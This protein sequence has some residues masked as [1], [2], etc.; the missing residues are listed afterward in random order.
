M[1]NTKQKAV[2][3]RDEEAGER[4]DLS[5]KLQHKKAEKTATAPKSATEVQET[6]VKVQETASKVAKTPEDATEAAGMAATTSE[7]VTEAE[8][9]DQALSS[10]QRPSDGPR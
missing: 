3:G 8:G 9:T 10:L 6:A 4:P 1:N 7:E 2:T 5:A